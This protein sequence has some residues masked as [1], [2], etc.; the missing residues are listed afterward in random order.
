[1]LIAGLTGGMGC[2]KSFVANAFRDLGC[3]IVEADDLG[4]DVMKPGGGAYHNIVQIFGRDIVDEE[5]NLN[6]HA[7]AARVFTDPAALSKLNNI[8]HPAVR[9]RAR[10][11]FEQI[12]RDHG[13]DAIVIYVAA[14]LIESGANREVEKIVVVD[15]SKER[16][17]ERAMRRPGAV[18]ADVLARIATQLPSAARLRYADYVIDTNGTKEETLRQTK[19]VYDELRRLAG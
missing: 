10:Q 18:E 14:I 6:R 7:L 11:Q 1:V 16:Q 2:G 15:C 3:H 17:F 9:A 12:R 4:R 19:E 8:V 13:D 5:G